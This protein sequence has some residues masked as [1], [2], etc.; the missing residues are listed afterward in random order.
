MGSHSLLQM[1]FLT[2]GMSLGLPHWRQIL[3]C[4]S[5]QGSP[6]LQVLSNLILK[7]P[8]EG[9]NVIVIL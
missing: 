9:I 6:N 8:E 3:Y 4:L 2:Q 1:I 5:H 7:Q